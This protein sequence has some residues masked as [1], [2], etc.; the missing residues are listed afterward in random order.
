MKE[1]SVQDL[2][3]SVDN[4]NILNNINLEVGKNEFVGLI[5]PNGA[6]KSTLLKNIYNVL[7]PSSGSIYL[8]GDELSK[9]PNKEIAKRMSVLSQ[10]HNMEFDM[11]VLEIV[12]LGRYAHD[13]SLFKSSTKEDIEIAM[14][15][16]KKVGL[17]SFADRNFFSL[18]GGEKQRVLLA[19]VLTQ[20]CKFIVL[21]EPTN[22]LDVMYQYQTMEILKK[23][24]V[25]V[26]SSIHDLN[27][28]AM[29]CDR[30]ILLQK[31]KVIDVGRPEEILTEE[32]ISAIFHVGVES[33]VNSKTGKIQIYYFPKE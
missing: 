32:K 19:R 6:G 7:K 24:N 21:D 29:Y 30:I 18:S 20:A 11:K 28:A 26:F 13:N 17:E 33:K 4:K 10:E 22:H 5:G 16:L 14:A 9:L 31:G 2:K 23:E 27:I 8:T 1:L 25:T 15:S 12:L 3:F